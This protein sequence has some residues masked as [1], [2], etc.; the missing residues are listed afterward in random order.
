MGRAVGM[1]ADARHPTGI[2]QAACGGKCGVARPLG[3]A[4]EGS[5]TVSGRRTRATGA[6]VGPPTA[7]AAH[8]SA[9]TSS[10]TPY[11]RA[12]WG[13][14]RR[15][16]VG[17]GV[18]RAFAS[19]KT[20]ARDA[21]H[22]EVLKLRQEVA[23]AGRSYEGAILKQDE[24]RVEVGALNRAVLKKSDKLGRMVEVL[25]DNQMSVDRARS[26]ERL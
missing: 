16:D 19:L 2:R 6:G 21:A 15:S 17:A 11:S 8:I 7:A 1:G 14:G 23:E 4:G 18:G 5:V 13:M 3:T 26:E 24:L 20:E 10:G 22:R 9:A 25:S 12:S